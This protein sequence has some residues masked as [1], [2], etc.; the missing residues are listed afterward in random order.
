MCRLLRTSL[1]CLLLLFMFCTSVSFASIQTQYWT[2]FNYTGTLSDFTEYLFQSTF[3]MTFD[4]FAANIQIMPATTSSANNFTTCFNNYYNTTT[5]NAYYWVGEYSSNSYG[6]TPNR[7]YIYLSTNNFSSSGYKYF[8]VYRYSNGKYYC[9]SFNSSSGSL[10]VGGSISNTNPYRFLKS[11]SNWF[12][13]SN[14]RIEN[15][16]AVLKYTSYKTNVIN[17]NI[18]G[19]NVLFNKADYNITDSINIGYLTNYQYY[20]DVQGHLCVY[21][22]TSNVDGANYWDQIGSFVYNKNTG[23]YNNKLSFNKNTGV[24]TISPNVL[25]YD[26]GYS[27]WFDADN[28]NGTEDYISTSE[29]FYFVVPIGSS[30]TSGDINTDNPTGVDFDFINSVEYL[31]QFSSGNT[32]FIANT[33]I[34]SG[35][36]SGDIFGFT[37]I[38]HDQWGFGDFIRVTFNNF[39]NVLYDYTDVS[40]NMGWL[41]V[42]NSS[43]FITPADNALI[44]IASLFC[45]CFLLMS[46]IAWFFFTICSIGVLDVDKIIKDKADLGLF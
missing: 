16:Q 15:P 1:L 40:Y 13:N 4:E 25:Q 5:Y 38:D 37:Y 33:L 11:N 2:S 30:A 28:N 29:V 39:L 26:H 32:D 23:Y 36:S 6:S 10:S 7:L 14:N 41:G 43:E 12:S 31:T 20:D 42:H 45:N 44:T 8:S 19:Q 24:V 17:I 22:G 35:D 46:S 9:D 3:H 27:L 18:N 21:S 34:P